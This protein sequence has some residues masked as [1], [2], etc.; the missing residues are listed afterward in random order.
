MR[1]ALPVASV[2]QRFDYFAA[3]EHE[4]DSDRDNAEH[5]ASHQ[6]TPV[7]NSAGLLSAKRIYGN[8]HN[9]D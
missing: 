1:E 3:K 8:R 6:A 9:L 7:R 4:Q 2:L 5:R